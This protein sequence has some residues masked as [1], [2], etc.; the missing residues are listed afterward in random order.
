ML[1]RNAKLKIIV[2]TKEAAMG[3]V[4]VSLP[5]TVYLWGAFIAL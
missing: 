1:I 2:R 4:V 3:I 5:C